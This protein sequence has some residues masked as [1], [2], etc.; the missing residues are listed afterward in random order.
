MHA[1][2]GDGQTEGSDEGQADCGQQDLRGKQQKENGWCAEIKE[3]ATDKWP[4]ATAGQKDPEEGWADRHGCRRKVGGAGGS[5]DER[6]PGGRGGCGERAHS[7]TWFGGRHQRWTARSVQGRL[8]TGGSGLA[9]GQVR[10]SCTGQGS[11]PGMATLTCGLSLPAPGWQPRRRR[12]AAAHGG[13]RAGQG[14]WTRPHARQVVRRG[15]GSEGRGRETQL[16]PGLTSGPTLASWLTPG[17]P[18]ADP[19]TPSH[20]RAPTAR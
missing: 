9:D 7:D 6:G 4:E 1:S 14:L 16:S 5:M 2:V 19:A 8:G 20:L 11:E 13:W 10:G 17:H 18:G 15:A 3:R 12:R